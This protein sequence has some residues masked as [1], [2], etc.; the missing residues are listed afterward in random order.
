MSNATLVS[1]GS[2]PSVRLERHLPDPPEVVWG[3]LTER[4]QLRNWFPCDVI[5]AGG[6]WRVGAGISFPFPADAIDLTLAG[7]VLEVDRPHRLAF[8]WGEDVLLFELTPQ[9]SGTDLVLV[10]ELPPGAA[11]RNAAGWDSCLDRLTGQAVPD[12]TWRQRFEVYTDAFEPA[13]GPQEGPPSGYAGK[14]LD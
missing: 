4:E 14:E 13:L 10:D 11:A 3:A 8:S 9:G 6:E 7:E 12:G 2:R 1:R 5:V